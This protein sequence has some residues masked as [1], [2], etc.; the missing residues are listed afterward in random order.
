ML[1]NTFTCKLDVEKP[2]VN[3]RGEELEYTLILSEDCLILFEEYEEK[4]S[5]GKLIFWA[6]LY[7]LLDMQINKMKKIASIN[8]FDDQRNEDKLIKF[9][10]DNI[11]FFREALVKRLS[12]LKIRVEAAKI[13]KG[14]LS[15]K[16][17]TDKEISDMKIDQIIQYINSIASQLEAGDISLYLV[18]TFMN[19]CEKAVEHYAALNDPNHLVYLNLMRK[20]LMIDGVQKISQNQ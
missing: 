15:E 6:T 19:L 1:V 8:F 20:I 3:S 17:L 11:L 14:Q 7:S 16:R 18:N 12:A 10:I 13:V 2:R 4:A 5:I 9:K